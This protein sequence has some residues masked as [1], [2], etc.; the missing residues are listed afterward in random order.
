MPSEKYITLNEHGFATESGYVKCYVVKD[1]EYIGN[2]DEFCAEGQGIPNNSYIEPAPEN[3]DGFAII[4]NGDK[5]EY[6][7]DHRDEKVY[8]TSTRVEMVLNELGEYPSGTTTIA[9]KTPYD[10]WDGN[11]W[12]TD[13]NAQ[14]VA[15]VTIAEKQRSHL[16]Q[17]AQA[18]ISLWQ[19]ELQLGII[20]DEDKASLIAWLA[21]IKALK[22][23]D[24]SAPDNIN[25]PELP[26]S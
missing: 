1:F 24:V 18:T 13:V 9:P 8:S 22:V 19:T 21:Y 7:A 15:N 2:Y 5:W 4:R 12:I 17:D 25:W 16:L 3:K 6:I 23:V 20:N 26:N 10:K 11:Q 14:L